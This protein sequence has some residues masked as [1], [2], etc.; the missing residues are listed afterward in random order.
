MTKYQNALLAG[1][2][3][4]ALV[5]G[6]GLASAQGMNQNGGTQA[7][8][9]ASPGESHG[10][11]MKN[12]GT[13]RAQAQEKTKAG[14]SAQQ[15][16]AGVSAQ[17]TDQS[18]KGGELQTQS[19]TNVGVNGKNGVKAGAETGAKTGAKTGANTEPGRNERNAQTMRHRNGSV[20][21]QGMRH[22]NRRGMDHNNQNAQNANQNNRTNQNAQNNGSETDK[23]GMAASS[24]TEHGR[25]NT[26]QQNN[27]SGQMQSRNGAE[28]VRTSSGTN[29]RISERQRTEIRRTVIDARNAPR[30]SSVQFNVDVDTVIPRAEF[31]RIHVV[32]V[33]EY[34]VR[35]DPRWRGFEYFVF[36]DEV[37][38]VNPRDLRIIAIVPV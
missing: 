21:E 6:T 16:K 9:S 8:Q 11:G 27:R 33:P 20:A 15:T 37:V 38:I 13:P 28:R 14:E 26:A 29:V 32:P 36:R 30:V 1:V 35:I 19:Q 2:A 34:L 7:G 17:N 3:A 22:K 5:A 18:G 24:Q 12:M 31:T 25:Q 10:A 23:H 4:L